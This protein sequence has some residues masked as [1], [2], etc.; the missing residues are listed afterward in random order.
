MGH[1]VGTVDKMKEKRGLTE[2]ESTAQLFWKGAKQIVPVA[3]AG[4]LDGLVFGILARQAGLGMFETMLMTL[5]VNAGSS[6]FAAV[7]MISQGIVGWPLL[8]STALINAR[9]LLY[10][11]SI[12]R[13][14]RNLPIWKLSIMAGQLN[15]E[16]YA[17]KTT[18]LAQGR[19]PSMAYFMGAGLG[20]YTIWHTCVFAGAM[21]GAMF[22]GTEQYGL[23][24]AFIATFLG[25]LAI[26]LTSR[27]FVK[28]AV[29]S[30]AAACLGYGLFGMTASVVIGTL[31]AVLM[32][33][34]SR[35]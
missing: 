32:G 21:F 29:V 27:Y 15:D 19:K 12:G 24:F 9:Q 22:T 26:N 1:G 2:G 8:I 13:A 30:A 3:S 7:G 23:D 33:V 18:Y 5:L 35:E 34:F 10:G 11:L 20:D 17:L 4:I 6:Q 31:A 25:F 16:T 14:F 28:V